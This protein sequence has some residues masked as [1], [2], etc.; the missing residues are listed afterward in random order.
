MIG[1]IFEWMIWRSFFILIPDNLSSSISVNSLRGESI[2]S[3]LGGSD[4]DNSGVNSAANTVL[5]FDIKFG[6]NVVLESSV[7]LE[8]LLWRGIDNVSNS[9]PLYGLILWTSSA[10]VDT[11]DGFDVSSVILVP[12]VVSPFYWHVVFI[13]TNIFI[14]IIINLL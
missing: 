10:A 3:V 6:D 14:K 9:E 12:T 5:H 4:L 7:F 8:I 11:D 2:L 13:Y 1:L